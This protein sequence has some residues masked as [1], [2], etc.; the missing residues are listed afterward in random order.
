MMALIPAIES[1]TALMSV[2]RHLVSLETG[3]KQGETFDTLI[4]SVASTNLSMR[5]M[6]RMANLAVGDVKALLDKSRS[7]LYSIVAVADRGNMERVSEMVHDLLSIIDSRLHH[8][9]SENND[10]N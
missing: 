8:M 5:E 9:E 6:A 2:L 3:Q 4:A 10:S 1:N 7:L